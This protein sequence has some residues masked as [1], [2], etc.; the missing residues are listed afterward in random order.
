MLSRR[1]RPPPEGPCRPNFYKKEKKTRG[2]FV[3]WA[4]LLRVLTLKPAGAQQA[5]P[6]PAWDTQS[7]Q[8]AEPSPELHSPAAA[9]AR[10][11]SS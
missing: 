4:A 10:L 7:Q 9:A 6:Q 3:P 1:A 11:A 8:K 2:R 5:P